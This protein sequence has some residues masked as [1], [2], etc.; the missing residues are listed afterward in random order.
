M[1]SREFVFK[2]LKKK[3]D[4]V[5]GYTGDDII[6]IANILKVTSR[7]LRRRLNNWINTF[8]QFKQLIYLGKKN[9][10]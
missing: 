9:P 2:H 6:E 3:Q 1:I 8:D 4:S 5:Y 7:G 10:Q